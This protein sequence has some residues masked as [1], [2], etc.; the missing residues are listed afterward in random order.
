M[1]K[2]KLAFFSFIRRMV[3]GEAVVLV[4]KIV[5]SVLRDEMEAALWSFLA[6]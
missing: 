6:S 5:L 4:F 3:G 2:W 1:A